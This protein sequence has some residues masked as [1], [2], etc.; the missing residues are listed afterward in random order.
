MDQVRQQVW[1]D[2]KEKPEL[3]RKWQ[4]DNAPQAPPYRHGLVFGRL[5]RLIKAVH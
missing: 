1:P 4:S 3:A 5:L 2:K